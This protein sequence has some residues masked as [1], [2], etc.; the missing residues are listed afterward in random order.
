MIAYLL[1]IR[2]H[3]VAIDARLSANDLAGQLIKLLL[4]KY[5]LA[6]SVE[7]VGISVLLDNRLS[8][9]TSTE[10]RSAAVGGAVGLDATS[11]SHRN[12]RCGGLLVQRLRNG[13]L[14]VDGRVRLLGMSVRMGGLRVA[15]CCACGAWR[16]GSAAVGCAGLRVDSRG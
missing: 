14:G 4:R 13:H 7:V 9:D 3:V 12:G 11:G 8:L 15:A 2:C 16:R 5:V 1:H 10:A 6:V